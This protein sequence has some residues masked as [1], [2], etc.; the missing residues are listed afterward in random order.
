MK[1][2]ILAIITIAAAAFALQTGS[3][4]T[5]PIKVRGCLQGNGSTG[6]PWSLRGVALPPPPTAAPAG[7]PGGRGDGGARGGG[8]GEH[9]RPQRLRPGPEHSGVRR[10]RAAVEREDRGR[11]ELDHDA[12]RLCEYFLP[13]FHKSNNCLPELGG[14][15]E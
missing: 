5:E 9:L 7:A 12:I 15:V 8:A 3:V 11:P 14:C 4:Q 10:D 1:L 13:E 6:S 2:T